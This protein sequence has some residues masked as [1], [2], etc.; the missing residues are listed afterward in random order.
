LFY[1]LLV[2]F[3]IIGSEQEY[4][5]TI[6][7]LGGGGGRR[8]PGGSSGLGTGTRLPSS[9]ISLHRFSAFFSILESL[10]FYPVIFTWAG[11]QVLVHSGIA[12]V[13]HSHVA[14]GD[15]VLV[16]YLFVRVLQSC[17]ERTLWS[18]ELHVIFF[19]E[20]CA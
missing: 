7:G 1:P 20:H 5:H 18:I 8:T 3:F 19:V 11:I 13:D 2:N 14:K 4:P 12:D 16:R 9:S 15:D 17:V 10:F 6:I